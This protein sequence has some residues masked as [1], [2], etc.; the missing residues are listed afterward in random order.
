MIHIE[1]NKE[2]HSHE[3]QFYNLYNLQRDYPGKLEIQHITSAVYDRLNVS[4]SDR[5]T[6]AIIESNNTDKE[7]I[8]SANDL[9]D[10][11]G[12]ATYT[13]SHMFLNRP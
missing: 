5:E 10:L 6:I 12:L 2:E 4:I 8:Q 13:I 9:V 3:N 7:N 1:K 11:L